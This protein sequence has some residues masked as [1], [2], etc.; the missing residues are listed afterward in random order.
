MPAGE[1]R[2]GGIR[3]AISIIGAGYNY[4]ASGSA[5]NVP[6]SFSLNAGDA[7]FIY[8]TATVITAPAL[9]GPSGGGV[10]WYQVGTTQTGIGTN[11]VSCWEGTVNAPVAANSSVTVTYTSATFASGT[12][13]VV[14]NGGSY[15]SN[16][17]TGTAQVCASSLA[18]SIPPSEVV[19]GFQLGLSGELSATINGVNAQYTTNPGGNASTIIPGTG[20]PQGA[21]AINGSNTVSLTQGTVSPF[22]ITAIAVAQGGSVIPGAPGTNVGDWLKRHRLKR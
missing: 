18:V 9:S 10:T 21:N 15:S 19:F 11:N 22:T 13:V 4:S 14:R 3:V 1:Y 2:S 8:C 6:I 12:L 20:F 7:I 5:F 17:V 16:T